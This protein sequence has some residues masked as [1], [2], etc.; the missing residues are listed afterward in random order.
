MAKVSSLAYFTGVVRIKNLI[1]L[2]AKE[3]EAI[4]DKIK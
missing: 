1:P 4:K 2:N 3:L